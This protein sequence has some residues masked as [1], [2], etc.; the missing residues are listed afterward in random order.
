MVFGAFAIELLMVVS[1]TA[2]SLVNNKPVIKDE[3]KIKLEESLIVELKKFLDFEE[4]TPE[5][6]RGSLPPVYDSKE[7]LLNMETNSGEPLLSEIEEIVETIYIM[8][9]SS[10]PVNPVGNGD[11]EYWAVLIGADYNWYY[12][13]FIMS[14]HKNVECMYNM[15]LA[16]NHWQA[17][18]IK[19]LTNED[20]TLAKIVAALIWLD[21]MD[22]DNDISLVY[23]TAHGSKLRIKNDKLGINKPLDLPPF[24][25]EDGFDEF[26]TTYWTGRNPLNIMTDDLLN[27]L[28]NRLDSQGIAVLIDACFSGGMFDSNHKNNRVMMSSSEEDEFGSGIDFAKF[29]MIGM[30]G[31]ADNINDGGNGDGVVSAEEAFSYAAP[32]YIDLVQEY[33]HPVIKDEY[34]GELQLTG[35]EF[36]PTQPSWINGQLVGKTNTSYNYSVVSTDPEDHKIRYGWDWQVEGSGPNRAKVCEWS[37]FYASGENCNRSHLWVEPG[38]YDIRV[39][40]QDE[41]GAERI[42]LETC[43]SYDW[44][45]II[46][47]DDEI[48][49]QF[50][51]EDPLE[52][53][54]G[55]WGGVNKTIWRAQSFIPTVNNLSKVTLQ[56]VQTVNDPLSFDILIRSNLSGKNLVELSKEVKT[57]VRYGSVWIEFDFPDLLVTPGETYYII[58]SSNHSHYF[59]SN[60]VNNQDCVMGYPDSYLEGEG[61]V[62]YDSGENWQCPYS[63]LDHCFVT[64][65][66]CKYNYPTDQC[67]QSNLSSSQQFK[68]SFS[69]LTP[70]V[71]LKTINR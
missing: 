6:I 2:V 65:S 57:T 8:M 17:D 28:L 5:Q 54:V 47:S 4:I 13:G 21:L 44:T 42:F 49:D 64:Y 40:S 71:L 15:L 30:Q 19:V 43:W 48:A 69:S 24:D 22:D 25:E 62:S 9:G 1:A 51:T 53:S 14:F 10:N 32:R 35:V 60:W 41:F 45:T 16:S 52:Y 3:E 46:T 39:K 63:N 33:C 23:Y 67:L 18:H 20:V 37:K 50:Q 27:Y 68:T 66:Q 36:P 31:Y 12:N 26:L 59:G 34:E 29:M 7:N 70:Q 38:I 61:Y 56:L 11:T 55:I 58:L